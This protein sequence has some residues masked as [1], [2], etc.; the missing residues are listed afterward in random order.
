MKFI[1][2][3]PLFGVLSWT[4][5]KST[6]FRC[7]FYLNFMKIRVLAIFMK[8]RVW[9]SRLLWYRVWWCHGCCGTGLVVSW[10][11]WYPGVSW[12]VWYPGWC[13]I[14]VGVLAGVVSGWWSCLAWYPVWS[15]LAWYPVVVLTVY[16][17]WSWLC[18][19]CGPLWYRLWST[20]VPAVVI[21]S[22]P[23]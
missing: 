6:T 12:L 13:G 3:R 17:L 2:N 19:G 9:W 10:L 11:V 14:R 18:T 4:H 7:F 8:I 22:V 1:E 5:R 21:S 16:R 23:L 15:C 20:V